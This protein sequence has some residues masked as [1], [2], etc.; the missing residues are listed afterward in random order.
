MS[1]AAKKNKQDIVREAAEGL[2]EMFRTGQMP[3]AVALSIIRRKAGDD[4][5]SFHWSLGNQLILMMHGIND[6]RGYRQW[7]E[8][9]RQVKKGSEAIYILGPLTK[10][11]KEVDEETGEERE[12]VVITGFKP[13]PVFAYEQ[14]EGQPL[15][16]P[17]YT[18]EKLPPFWGV[19]EYLGIE[20]EY[21][22]ETG[23]YYGSYNPRARKITLCSE[24]PAVY[25]HELA[26]A[27]RSTFKELNPGDIQEEIIAET[28]AAVLCQLQ[29]ITGYECEAYKYIRE[30]VSPKKEQ[31]VLK[32]ITRLLSDVEAIVL[33]VLEIAERIESPEVASKAKQ[34]FF[35][36]TFLGEVI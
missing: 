11:V 13:I 24:D 16:K 30:Y 29:G 3:E 23:G 34:G 10:K 36:C 17:D 4:Q 1:K 20:I 33:K 5:P 9:G 19:A 27:I 7:Q 14:T 2:L 12:E 35:L 6:A 32:S 18:P 8:V 25:F 28:S 15:Q 26:H 22:P 21:A 31:E